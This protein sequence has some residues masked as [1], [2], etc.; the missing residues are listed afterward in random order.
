MKL[1]ETGSKSIYRVQALDRA[2]DILEAFSYQRRKMLLSEVVAHTGLKK[3]TAKRLLSNLTDRGYL[4][5]DSQSKQYELGL[6]LFELG[7]VVHAS[8]SVRKAA[9]PHMR[10][11][12]DE[13]GLNVLLGQCQ[14]D[15]LVYI[16]KCEGTDEIKISSAI[17]GR[18]PL[19]FGMLGQILMAYMNKDRVDHNLGQ[20]PL[21]AFTINSITDLDAF[22]LR[23]AEIRQNGYVIESGEAHRGIMGLAAPIR[24]ASRKVVA[25]VG[26]ALPLPEHAGQK[27]ID[28]TLAMVRTTAERI[29]EDLGYL[30]I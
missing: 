28:H 1:D 10:W 30:K 24:D 13:T 23:L 2:L 11:L 8:F 5:R 26:A 12:R 20:T 17:G 16:D 25:A 27:R 29:S 15:Q 9:G 4:K 18:R 19:H 3:S 22:W 7:G 6:R 14:E 21:Q